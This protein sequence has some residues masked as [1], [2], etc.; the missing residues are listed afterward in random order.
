MDWQAP[1]SLLIVAGAAFFLFRGRFARRKYRFQ[2]HSHCGCSGAGSSIPQGTI[3][4]RAR[5]GERP[6]VIVQMK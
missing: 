4:F 6:E 2:E 1:V 3:V 5:K